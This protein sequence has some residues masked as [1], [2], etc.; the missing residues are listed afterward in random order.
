MLEWYRTLSH[1][2][3]SCKIHLVWCTK[4]RYEVLRWEIQV[5]CRDIIRQT[6][7]NMDIV[8]L[9]WVVSKDHVHLLIEYPPKWWIS[10]IV[11]R[12]KWRSSRKLQQEFEELRK[13]YRWQHMWW[14]W[15]FAAT[16]WNVTDEMIDEYLKHHKSMYNRIKE[17]NTFILE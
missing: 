11:R 5:R 14:I 3:T 1:T 6:C 2:V 13:R 10:E 17:D 15:Y 4:Y 7:E 8:I 9:R 16:T 12:L